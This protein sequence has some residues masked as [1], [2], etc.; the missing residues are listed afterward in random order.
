MAIETRTPSG[1]IIIPAAADGHVHGRDPGYTE[2][3]DYR[4]L[5]RGAA[6]GGVTEILDMPN[7]PDRPT[8]TYERVM[9]KV[10]ILT[11]NPP[12]VDIGLSLKATHQSTREMTKAAD[13]VHFDKAYMD[14]TTGED[15]PAN[16]FSHVFRMNPRKVP[17]VIHAEGPKRAAYAL[18]LAE[19][20]GLI[21]I[22][23]HT[24]ADQLGV[25]REFRERRPEQVFGE[26]TPHHLTL[27]QEDVPSLPIPGLGYMKPFLQD[28]ESIEQLWDAIKSRLLSTIGTDHAP[29][30]KEKKLATP[31]AFG[32]TGI[33]TSVIL[34]YSEFMKRGIGLDR[35]VEM[36]CT[37]PRQIYR[38]PPQPESWIYLDPNRKTTITGANLETKSHL[39][40]HEGWTVDLAMHQ[41][42]LRGETIVYEDEILEQRQPRGR[43]IYP[44]R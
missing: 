21:A 30:P 39:S 44:I 41:V 24:T 28:R 43:V 22:L 18:G 23:A 34:M 37:N 38:M 17:I 11:D 9:E 3:E 35:M 14:I 42:D 15:D 26:V 27:A 32:I 16:D 7:N 2:A 5:S 12:Y 13:L 31:P 40:A 6:R 1:L 19:Q 4:S 33:Q 10:Q 20:N 25:L 8:D 29:H 36:M